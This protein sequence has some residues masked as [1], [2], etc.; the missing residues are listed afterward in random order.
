MASGKFT[1]R[2]I[3]DW[4]FRVSK[5]GENLYWL[6][7]PTGRDSFNLDI[8]IRHLYDATFHI[9]HKTFRSFT[10]YKLSEFSFPF[11]LFLSLCFSFFLLR[12]RTTKLVIPSPCLFEEQ[13]RRDNFSFVWE[14]NYCGL[15]LYLPNF[16]HGMAGTRFV[17]RMR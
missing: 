5:S 2:E 1:T 16:A 6:T 3:K 11:S 15:P 17:R 4:Q 8:F 14:E 12:K 7:E 10:K 13:L 9:G